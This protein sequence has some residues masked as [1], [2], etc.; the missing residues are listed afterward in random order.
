MIKKA[1]KIFL[2]VLGSIF[3]TLMVLLLLLKYEISWKLT[4]VGL[5]KSPDGRYSVRFQ[6]VG[7]A[8]WPF[9]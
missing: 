1:V 6:S 5:E 4:D 8:D 3:L 9:V 2:C 7:E